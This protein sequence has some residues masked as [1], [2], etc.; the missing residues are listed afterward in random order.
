M[1][2]QST[3]SALYAR[4]DLSE[5]KAK[6]VS[7]SRRCGK[8]EQDSSDRKIEGKCKGEKRDDR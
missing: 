4:G 7:T 2:F 5:D 6:P 8:H 1:G 3:A